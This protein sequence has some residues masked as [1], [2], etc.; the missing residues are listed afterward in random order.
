[1][2]GGAVVKV[3]FLNGDYVRGGFFKGRKQRNKNNIAPKAIMLYD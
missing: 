1:V 3:W 2:E